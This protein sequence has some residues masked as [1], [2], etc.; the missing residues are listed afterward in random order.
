M[1][2]VGAYTKDQCLMMFENH[3]VLKYSSEEKMFSFGCK[4]LVRDT[5]FFY[6]CLSIRKSVSS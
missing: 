4:H 2:I 3:G 5:F 6:F 1:F